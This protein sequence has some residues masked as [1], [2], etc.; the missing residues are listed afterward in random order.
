MFGVLFLFGVLFCKILVNMTTQAQICLPQLM[1]GITKVDFIDSALVM[2]IK[3][4]EIYILS[5]VQ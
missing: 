1:L 4:L 2:E 3:D 5:H